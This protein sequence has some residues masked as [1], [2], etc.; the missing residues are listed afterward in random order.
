[1]FATKEFQS[2]VV[3]TVEQLKA[4][5]NDL[6]RRKA[7]LQIQLK[8]LITHTPLQEALNGEI[9]SVTDGVS[10]TRSR[11]VQSPERIKR[12]IATMG[13]TAIEDKKTVAMHE[14]KA[15][16]LQ[17]K[18]TALLNIEKVLLCFLSPEYISKPH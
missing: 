18:V 2:N 14:A 8:L 12:T 7:S 3:Q 9:A 15:R 5:K 11:I 17:A 10:R 13:S 4:D 1:M 6:L 16:V